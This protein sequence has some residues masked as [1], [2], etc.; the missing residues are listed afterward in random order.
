MLQDQCSKLQ[1]R[2]IELEGGW[3]DM[4]RNSCHCIYIPLLLSLAVLICSTRTNKSELQECPDYPDFSMFQHPST[5]SPVNHLEDARCQW[6]G[7]ETWIYAFTRRA[8]CIQLPK[9]PWATIEILGCASMATTSTGTNVLLTSWYSC[10][11][12][13]AAVGRCVSARR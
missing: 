2:K 5:G 6:Q 12:V 13:K 9:V 1:P 11:W 10:V 3:V 4:S 7:L 8:G